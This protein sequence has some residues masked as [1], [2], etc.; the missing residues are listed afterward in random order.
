[1]STAVTIARESVRQ[2][3]VIALIEELDRWNDGLYPPEASY[4]LS[5]DEL[6]VPEIRFLVARAA[7][8]AVGCGALWVHAEYGEIKRMYT[9][10]SVRGQGIGHRLLAEIE[11]LAKAE[12][13]PILRLETG[14]RSEEALRLYIRA[15][16]LPRGP[17]GAYADHPACVFL[18]KRLA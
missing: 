8:R 10:P 3:D 4:L 12:R 9:R 5:L 18:E 16:F 17:F 11:R 15:G 13:L 1:M 6:D 14:D 7:G 2:P